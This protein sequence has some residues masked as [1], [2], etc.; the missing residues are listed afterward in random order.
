MIS[1]EKKLGSLA[2]NRV[3]SAPIFSGSA[4]LPTIIAWG[5]GTKQ[6]KEVQSIYN[7]LEKRRPDQSGDAKTLYKAS[8]RNSLDGTQIVS[9]PKLT[10][11]WGFF[12]KTVSGKIN[13]NLDKLPW[14]DR[15][16]KN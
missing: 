3:A 10:K 11:L 4:A 12:H 8:L 14:Q 2:I 5:T 13:D 1:P 9:N 7:R 15:S 16:K 6:A